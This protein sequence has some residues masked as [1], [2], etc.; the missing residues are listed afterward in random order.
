M[1]DYV[2]QYDQYHLHSTYSLWEV[3]PSSNNRE[4]N[5]FIVLHSSR[6]K[7]KL[8]TKYATELF[9]YYIITKQIVFYQFI[10]KLY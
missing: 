3:L 4:S 10:G 6:E 1:Q 2:W 8:T 5:I 9:I 7:L